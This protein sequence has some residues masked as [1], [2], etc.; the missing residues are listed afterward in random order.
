MTTF[1]NVSSIG[2]KDTISILEDNIKG[3]LD[4]SFINI[5]GFINVKIPTS[6]IPVSGVVNPSNFHTFQPATDPTQKNKIWETSRKDW[7]YESGIVYDS[8]SP[9]AFSGIYVN[10]S[11]LPA[12]TGSG[13]YGYNINY[14]LGRVVF[15]NSIA[16]NS[17]VTAQYSYRYVQTYK[18]NDSFWW[19][20]VQKETYN[21]TNFKTNED[22]SITSNH[23]VQLPAI[24]I[25]LIPRTVLI[26]Y[27]IGDSSN[28]II[29]D[30]LLHI[31]AQNANQ[32]NSLM[33]ILL[34]QKDKVLNLYD[35]NNVVKNSVY[36]LNKYGNI[37][38]SGQNYP[39]LSA[40]YNSHWC[41]IKESTIGELNILSS[42][43][44]NGIIRWSIEIYP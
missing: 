1:H 31:F 20:E 29:Q 8:S 11:F 2:H 4:W 26:P 3:F 17:A 40:N 9:T 44:Y 16:A 19:K 23:R 18:S 34:H 38:P 37:N 10:N 13:S 28:I 35:V 41:T 30:I 42:S 27:Q 43:L 25:E 7:V 6:G 32:R 14:P 33:D 39:N 36:P 5:G 22:Y 12:P 24:V 21:P 15:T